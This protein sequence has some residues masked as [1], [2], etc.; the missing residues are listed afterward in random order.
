M[1]GKS[2]PGQNNSTEMSIQANGNL[3][4]DPKQCLKGQ[5]SCEYRHI[6]RPNCKESRDLAGSLGSGTI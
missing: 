1:A 2:N 6:K 5:P 4:Q 3:S